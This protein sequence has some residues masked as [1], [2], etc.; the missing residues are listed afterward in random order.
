M[1]DAIKLAQRTPSREGLR[2][3]I[4]Y[5]GKLMR[6]ADIDPDAIRRYVASYVA[7]GVRSFHLWTPAG[8]PSRGLRA[9]VEQ[10]IPELREAFAA[11][12]LG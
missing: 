11:G 10:V 5:V 3:Q 8:S 12:E 6:T 4:H 1:N 7:V 9:V 2:R